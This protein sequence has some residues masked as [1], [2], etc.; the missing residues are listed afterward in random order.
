MANIPAY[1]CADRNNPEK[2]KLSNNKRKG[3]GITKIF[4]FIGER[5]EDLA[6][7]GYS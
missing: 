5:R 6:H 2:K 3:I 4:H 1:L 7:K